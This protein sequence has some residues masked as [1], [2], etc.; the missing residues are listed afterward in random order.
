MPQMFPALPFLMPE[1]EEDRYLPE[2]PRFMKVEGR[3]V[4]LWVNIQTGPDAKTGNIHLYFFDNGERRTLPQSDRPGFVVPDMDGLVL[5]GMGKKLVYVQLSD[6]HSGPATSIPD[7]SPRTIIND[8]EASPD[9]AFV[10]F[11]TKD[12]EF[13]DSIA[14][15]YSLDLRTRA[16]RTILEGQT[17]S[18]GKVFQQLDGVL[19]LLDIDTP[20]RKVMRYRVD[21][22]TME[23]LESTL[24]LDVSDQHGFP[25]GMVASGENHVIIAFYNPALVDFGRAVELDLRTG[26]ETRV[27]LTPGAPRVTCPLLIERDGVKELYLTTCMEGMSDEDFKKCPNSGAIFRAVVEE[28]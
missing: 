21:P 25:D 20:T 13:R 5:I 19:F 22:D 7:D 17:C 28:R 27:W 14:K 24:A 9:G 15:L 1:R 26:A 8:A 4:L 12:T 10:V 16:G 23:I 3:D 2:G 11:G 18:N 6:N